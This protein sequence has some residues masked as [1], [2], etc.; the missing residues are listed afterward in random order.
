MIYH[1]HIII[2]HTLYIAKYIQ[3]E[4]TYEITLNHASVNPP[5]HINKKQ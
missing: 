2:R 5:Q 1:P 3:L 4:C